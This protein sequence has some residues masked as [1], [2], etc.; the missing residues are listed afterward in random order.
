MSVRSSADPLLECGRP[1][2]VRSGSRSELGDGFAGA[3]SA[4]RIMQTTHFVTSEGPRSDSTINGQA[5]RFVTLPVSVRGGTPVSNGREAGSGENLS[6]G[7]TDQRA[8]IERRR[9]WLGGSRGPGDGPRMAADELLLGAG[10]ATSSRQCVPGW[11]LGCSTHSGGISGCPRDPG[12][13]FAAAPL[14]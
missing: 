6:I 10:C 13:R 9:G 4:A 3:H 14:R 2:Q 8:R 5:S 12:W 11:R 7:Q 1:R